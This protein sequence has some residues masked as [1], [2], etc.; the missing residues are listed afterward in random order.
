M[1]TRL[2]IALFFFTST[3]GAQTH[4]IDSLKKILPSL[5]GAVEVNALNALATEFYFYWVHSDSALKYAGLSYKKA[6]EMNYNTGQV[7]ALCIQAGVMGRLLGKPIEMAD[8]ARQA[9]TLAEKNKN[10]K[11]LSKAYYYLGVAKTIQGQYELANEPFEKARQFAIKANDKFSLGWAEQGIGFMHFKSSKFWKSFEH[12]IEAQQIGREINDSVLTTLSLVIIARTFN[13]VGDHQKALD[14]YHHAFRY[15]MPFIRLWSHHEDMAYAHLQLKQYDSALYYQRLNN[16]DLEHMTTDLKVRKKFMPFSVG[17]SIDIQLGQKKYDSVLM[18]MLPVI[19]KL[20]QSH[21]VIPF[22]QALMAVAKA[23]KEK[24]DY[25][26]ALHYTRDLYEATRLYP[27]KR[28]RKDAYEM[29]ASVFEKLDQADSAYFY[30]KQYTTLNDSLETVQ[31]AGRTALYLAASEGENKIRLLEKDREINQQQLALNKKKLQ[32]ES[33]LRNLLLVS[34]AVLVAL[35]FLLFRNI[36]LKRKNEKLRSEKEQSALKRKTLELEMQALRAQMNPH[37]IFNCLSA[38]DNL[39]QT[40]QADRATSYLARFARLI[41]GVLD[42][43]KNNVVPFQKDFE[44]LRLYLEMEQ[45]RCNNKFSFDLK[46]DEEL[47]SGDYKIPPLIIQPFIENAIHHGL[48]NKHDNNR[49]L[50]VDAQLQG[51]QIIFSVFDNGIGRK[52]AAIIKE[53]NKPGQQSYGIAITTE[54]IHLHNK[55]SNGTDVEILDLEEA[56][57]GSGTQAIIR[58]NNPET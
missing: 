20:R 56:G 5:T 43:S 26:K 22:M 34:L 49:R 40:N 18:Q 32:K 14:Y 37:F 28:L 44:T 57:V 10:L 36:T 30:F 2:I 11:S 58:I 45:F 24:G 35:S 12:L 41:R 55:S 52:N 8:Y 7:D 19:E 33:G 4:R 31:Y 21:D 25:R 23:Y 46:A 17:Y 54:R 29:L 53:R 51:E 42:S 48:L 3:C 9:V 16:Y 13:V 50:E 1:Y 15:S 47:L 6:T 27:S 39:I 38:I